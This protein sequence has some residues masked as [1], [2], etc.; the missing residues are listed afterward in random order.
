M[1][2]GMQYQDYCI[3]VKFCE[4]GEEWHGLLPISGLGSRQVGPGARDMGQAVRCRDLVWKIGV[5]THSLVSRHGWLFGCCDTALGVATD[6]EGMRTQRETT[7]AYS[8]SA[9]DP[10]AV[11]H[12]LGHYVEH[13]SWTLFLS[14]HSKKKK[15]KK[16]PP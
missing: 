13:C 4:C 7:H 3:G 14:H 5:A 6:Q 2:E 9:H 16:R 11:V 12:C 8:R 15:K 1:Y 10:P